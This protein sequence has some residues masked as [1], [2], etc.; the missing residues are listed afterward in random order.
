MTKYLSSIGK[1]AAA[2]MVSCLVSSAWADSEPAILNSI[3]ANEPWRQTGLV[4]DDA[5]YFNIGAGVV[6]MPKYP[7]ASGTKTEIVPLVGAN[8]GRYFIGANPDAGAALA[9]GAYLLRD[10]NW[11]VGAA[12]AYDTFKPRSESDSQRLY[13]LGDIDRTTHAELFAIYAM[14]WAELRASV[15]SDIGGRD[16]GTFATLDFMARYQATPS[17][18]LTAGP[19][20]TW[21]NSQH[22]QTFFGVDY[23]QSAKSQFPQY[24]AG[25]GVNAY[26]ISMGASYRLAPQWSLA[27][28][29]AASRLQGDAG[30][31]PIVE[32]KTQMTYGVLVGYQF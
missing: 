17:L 8:Y 13:G 3:Y 2:L 9:L 1:P 16:Q 30:D 14:S 10:S 18:T 15:Q 22:N 7:G 23:L 24:A 29:V 20:L 28:N 21:G 6:N 19:G 5:W 26:R 27:L 11:R 4:G 31:S 32:K 12:I 25:S